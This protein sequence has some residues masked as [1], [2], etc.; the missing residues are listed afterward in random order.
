M[1]NFLTASD[2]F[3]ITLANFIQE[4]FCLF[5]DIYSLQLNVIKK[6]NKPS[7]VLGVNV[8]RP[9]VVD[10]QIIKAID[11]A[12]KDVKEGQLDIQERLSEQKIA[13]SNSA[14][15]KSIVYSL[16]QLSDLSSLSHN[17]V[18]NSPYSAPNN[19]TTQLIYNAFREGL[20]I[21]WPMRPEYTIMS[22]E[23]DRCCYLEFVEYMLAQVCSIDRELWQEYISGKDSFSRESL[24][25]RQAS[26]FCRHSLSSSINNFL[27]QDTLIRREQEEINHKVGLAKAGKSKVDKI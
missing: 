16:A 7:I 2:Q 1:P 15:P 4:N 23:L 3:K 5:P 9:S 27:G 19:A 6:F 20:F 22:S 25:N 18:S 12:S 21:S 14:A 24:G 26:S 8:Y 17:S 11:K 10:E 13:P